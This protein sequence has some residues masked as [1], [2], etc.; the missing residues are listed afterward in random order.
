M[1]SDVGP[2]SE[3]QLITNRPFE[4]CLPFIKQWLLNF[5]GLKEE[6]KIEFSEVRDTNEGAETA[7]ER[8]SG[9]L[10]SVAAKLSASV[11]GKFLYI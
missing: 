7:I 4:L 6:E 10:K 9:N 5:T 1:G 8:S 2:I 3:V 11:C